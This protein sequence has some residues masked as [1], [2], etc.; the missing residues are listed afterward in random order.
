MQPNT[1]P[2]A[3][4]LVNRALNDLKVFQRKEL[5]KNFCH[6]AHMLGFT[7][8]QIIEMIEKLPK[9]KVKP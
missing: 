1:E 2:D 3:P 6:A 4:Q 5:V 7:K 9:P 8:E